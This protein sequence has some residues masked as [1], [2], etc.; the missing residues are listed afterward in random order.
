MGINIES[1][2]EAR[3][4]RASKDEGLTGAHASFEVRLRT[5]LGLRPTAQLR[6]LLPQQRGPATGALRPMP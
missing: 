2:S 6:A 5:E 3:A 1:D 4:K